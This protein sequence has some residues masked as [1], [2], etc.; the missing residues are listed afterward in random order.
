MNQRV[1]MVNF[2]TVREGDRER[3]NEGDGFFESLA[4]VVQS[5]IVVLNKDQKRKR[6]REALFDD[7][8]KSRIMLPFRAIDII[9]GFSATSSNEFFGLVN[10]KLPEIEAY[11]DKLAGMIYRIYVK[12]SFSP[13]IG[14]IYHLFLSYPKEE[15][16]A[17]F[18]EYYEKYAAKLSSS[19]NKE[20]TKMILL[21]VWNFME[22]HA[23]RRG[24]IIMIQN[25]K[26][27]VKKWNPDLRYFGLYIKDT[28]RYIEALK[29]ISDKQVDSFIRAAPL[30]H[31]LFLQREIVFLNEVLRRVSVGEEEAT[32]KDFL[33]VYD[34]MKKIIKALEER[35]FDKATADQLR[36][37]YGNQERYGQQPEAWKAEL[38]RIIEGLERE[39]EAILSAQRLLF[40]LFN[41]ISIRVNDINGLEF[42][43]FKN[44]IVALI[45]KIKKIGASD[46]RRVLELTREREEY[47]NE[48]LKQIRE[49]YDT[50]ESKCHLFAKPFYHL[51]EG[52][53]KINPDKFIVDVR[54]IEEKKVP[55][56]Q[57]GR[58]IWSAMNPE[59][60]DSL[61]L[62]G[63]MLELFAYERSL[64][65]RFDLI[66]QEAT[67]NFE[68]G[69]DQLILFLE[70]LQKK[71]QKNTISQT[72]KVRERVI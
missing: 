1:K 32:W 65:S 34:N 8:N 72:A 28:R 16:F 66:G 52:L 17:H 30:Q 36:A 6:L 63:A 35:Y 33:N 59:Q 25:F 71:A 46:K 37:C 40:D 64:E 61:E 15:V 53:G 43:Q 31:I 55:L 13:L 67:S 47:W 26:E 24:Q 18:R 23:K 69:L 22:Q 48:Q 3:K 45:A 38:K 7:N 20:A 9:K 49:I 44:Q 12:E 70:D 14:R 10:E 19:N 4:Q 29:G 51:L 11:D 5:A 39:K 57:R 41:K 50:S 42:R 62:F 58:M 21:I 27:E 2:A 60:E 54:S 56:Y 68:I